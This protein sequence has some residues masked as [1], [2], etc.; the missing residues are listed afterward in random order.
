MNLE[1]ETNHDFGIFRV[2]DTV[3]SPLAEPMAALLRKTLTLVA[4]SYPL[5]ILRSELENHHFKQV[6]HQQ[7]INSSH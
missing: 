3:R 2:S 1:S 4:D 5:V 6:H 7:F